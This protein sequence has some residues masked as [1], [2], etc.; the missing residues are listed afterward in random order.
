MAFDNK[1]SVLKPR[2]SLD[3]DN[4][5]GNWKHLRAHRERRDL[6]ERIQNSSPLWVFKTL[7]GMKEISWKFLNGVSQ[8]IAVSILI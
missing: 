1:Q 7:N 5:N 8:L 6:Y 4:E 2:H 3:V